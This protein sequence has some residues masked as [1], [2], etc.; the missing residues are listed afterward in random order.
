MTTQVPPSKLVLLAATDVLLREEMAGALRSHG[1]QVIAVRDGLTLCDYLETAR[2]SH[3]RLPLP[4][5]IVSDVNLGGYG[6]P[7]ICRVISRETLSAP[8]ILLAARTQPGTWESAEQVG[9]ALV[10]DKPVACSQLLEAVAHLSE[11]RVFAGVLAWPQS[12]TPGTERN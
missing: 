6:G 2:F 4:D 5:V 8:V 12:P 11:D 7:E 1:Y 3:G 10:L 9:A